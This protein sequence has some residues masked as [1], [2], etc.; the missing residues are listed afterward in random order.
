ERI[1]HV[2]VPM[3]LMGTGLVLVS[4]SAGQPLLGL[5]LLIVLVGA[6]V[7]AH[8]PAFWAIPTLFLGST[9]AASAIGFINMVG[10][11]GGSA[12]PMIVGDAAKDGDFTTGLLRIG[13]FPF[14]G[15]IVI[16]LVGYFGNE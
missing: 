11:F 13:I 6:N 3:L 4:Y 1:W 7:Y 9:A 2:A 5:A 8:V 12:G 10:N 16:L 15:A 14:I